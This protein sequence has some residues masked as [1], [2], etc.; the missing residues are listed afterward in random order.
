MA[1]GEIFCALCSLSPG[2]GGQKKTTVKKSVDTKAHTK[3]QPKQHT[4][5]TL[6]DSLGPPSPHHAYEPIAPKKINFFPAFLVM[7]LI[8]FAALSYIA[9]TYHSWLEQGV[10]L[11]ETAATAETYLTQIHTLE[12]ALADAQSQLSTSELAL[13]NATDTLAT[14]ETQLGTTSTLA[15]ENQNSMTTQ[16]TELEALQ[17][18]NQSLV[19]SLETVVAENTALTTQVDNLSSSLAASIEQQMELSNAYEFMSQYVVF[20]NGDGS[21]T[22]HRYGCSEFKADNFT[23]YNAALAESNGYTPCPLC[24]P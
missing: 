6:A 9:F 12:T 20:V 22:Y 13:E 14:L 7:L 1:E 2:D 8:A 23:V 16:Q 21:T 4:K 24:F 3:P 15:T 17:A 5:K 11:E 19:T 10:V 18:E